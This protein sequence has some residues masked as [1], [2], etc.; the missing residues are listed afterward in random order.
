MRI[1]IDISQIVYRGGVSRYTKELIF[2][3]CKIDR[4]NKY[5]VF[6]SSLRQQ[7]ILN[8]FIDSLRSNTSKLKPKLYPIPPSIS[9]LLFNRI[10]LSIDPFIGKVDIFHSSDWTQPKTKAR[11]VTTV[12]D[13][14]PLKFPDQHHPKIVEV[15]KRRLELVKK[16]VDR[17]IA[18]S[19]NTKKDLIE[20]LRIPERKI[21][22]I[23][24]APSDSFKPQREEEIGKVKNKFNIK[25]DYIL[26][27]ATQ[28][29]RKNPA[30]L[31]EAYDLIKKDFD[32]EL[33]VVGETAKGEREDIIRT[34]FLEDN[35]LA[36]LYS[37]AKVFAYPSIYEGFGLPVV[38]AMAC[39]APVVCSNI[40]S[41]PEVGGDAAIYVDPNSSED[42]ASGVKKALRLSKADHEVTRKKSL[43]QAKKF[44]WDKTA[45]E[46]LKVYEEVR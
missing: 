34:G 20:I 36:V 44:S 24:E 31:F 29:S 22:V 3:L 12:H 41:L 27:V 7:K 1:C 11:K 5:V 19:A 38:E 13:L 26:T 43:D 14:A 10:R 37:G 30:K 46:T 39:G 9:E 40:S 32:L 25:K 15:H 42:I 28:G 8:D 33:V 2:N 6:G 4:D 21:V 45:R 17:I 23:Y 18:V 16:E 35:D